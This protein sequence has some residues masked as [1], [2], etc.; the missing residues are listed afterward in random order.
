MPKIF[1]S[2]RRQDSSGETTHIY[3]YLEKQFGRD[4]VF[5]DV[6]TIP[7]GVDFRKHLHAA[8]ARCD[9]VLAVIGRD[10][11]KRH[12]LFG[13]RRLD[14]PRDFVRIEIEA[15][16]QRDIRLIPVLVRDAAMPGPGDLPASIRDLAFRN[17]VQVRAGR[18]FR[19]DISRLIQALEAV[20]PQ[21]EAPTPAPPRPEE[22]PAEAPPDVPPTASP[23]KPATVTSSQTRTASRPMVEPPVPSPP[24]EAAQAG[25]VI[26]N[27]IGI[28]MVLIPAGEFLMGSPDSD[29]DA[30][31][32]EK[33]QHR[34]KITRPFYLG[35]YPV[36]Q[37][38]YERVMGKN[39][40][41]FK[42]DRQ[43]P[44]E[45][46]SW[47]DAAEFCR[48]LSEKEGKT[49]RLPTEAEW[50][51]ACRAGRTTKWCFGD[52]QSQ[53]ADYA[54]YD[55]NSGGTT[56]PVG[57][58]KP[59]AWGLYDMH[60]NVYE[61]C[62]DWYDEDYYSASPAAD[63]KGPDST[64]YRVLRGGS[65]DFDPWVTRSADRGWDAPDDRSLYFGFRLARTP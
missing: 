9:V 4:Q 51:Y 57:E 10:W 28:K 29:E 39:P 64:A 37:E 48:R 61:W 21:P 6:D 7:P 14:H 20:T 11:L 47:N 33:P 30:D 35:V 49:Y 2:Y 42:G 41:D 36:T 55:D 1:I 34:V 65:W 40:S 12:G 60:G 18:D 8:V 56:H 13:K 19:I 50:E 31:T 26:T 43:R 46:V 22:P 3:E 16:L 32:W 23:A 54:W 59:N 15:A 38:E 52:S 58:K 25:E 63:P 62:D 45:T 5:M 44:V 53:L 24:A 27:S 17:A